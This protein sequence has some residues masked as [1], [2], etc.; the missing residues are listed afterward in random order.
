MKT[1]STAISQDLR[2]RSEGKVEVVEGALARF[3]QVVKSLEADDPPQTLPVLTADERDAI[4]EIERLEPG[5][6][7]LTAMRKAQRALA[8]AAQLWAERH[9][10]QSIEGHLPLEFHERRWFF[11][12]PHIVRMWLGIGVGIAG[13]AAAGIAAFAGAKDAATLFISGASVIPFVA[14]LFPTR[15][16]VLVTPSALIIDRVVIPFTDVV[17]ISGRSGFGVV[18]EIKRRER[19]TRLTMGQD[20]FNKLRWAFEAWRDA[21]KQRDATTDAAPPA[22]TS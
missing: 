22:P 1:L 9:G 21:Q 20:L 13:A 14:A 3:E 5:A 16:E 17:D 2:I 8:D 15:R 4:D 11:G 19:T 7:L 12:E 18:V 10:L 6:E